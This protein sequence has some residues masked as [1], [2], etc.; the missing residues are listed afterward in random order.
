MANIDEYS[1]YLA[2]WEH[3]YL[4]P[5]GVPA[6]LPNQVF[7]R[8]P[9]VLV[10]FEHL[11]CDENGFKG[12]QNAA[13]QL[14][15]TNSEMFVKLASPKYDII[16]PINLRTP[17]RP[18][19]DD[20]RTEF[21]KQRGMSVAD[22]IS[23]GT[24]SV[25]E[26][27]QWRLRLLQPFREQHKL[28]LYDWPLARYEQPNAPR[29]IEQAVIDIL[30]LEVA[31]V[32][33]SKDITSELSPETKAIFDSLQEFE[34]EP[35]N[36][37]RSGRLSQSHY[38]EILK[39]RFRDYREV[40]MEMG[41]GIDHNL[42]RILRLRERF[43]RREGWKTFNDYLKAYDRDSSAS[44]LNE[45]KDQLKDRLDYCFKPLMSEYGSATWSLARMAIS[46]LPWIG[47][48]MTIA[49]MGKPARELFQLGSESIQFYRG[50]IRRSG[51][52][53]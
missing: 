14:Q 26:L 27:F 37:L 47:P 25:E 51:P 49:E 31:A 29:S 13:S 35:L 39:P 1:L 20:I 23:Q 6:G 28:I 12:E 5:D 33:L 32:P 9:W 45:I 19:L 50:Q 43:G 38:L 22:A 17:L 42:E 41:L 30:K 52:R 7:S 44:E 48:A 46:L 10:F 8:H 15:W 36:E 24:V 21:Y 53:K 11:Y 40:D 34:R 16:K 2:S 4:L 3:L 18:H